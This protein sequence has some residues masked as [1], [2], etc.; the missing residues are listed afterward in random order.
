MDKKP[1]ALV[2]IDGFGYNNSLTGNA[3]AMAKRPSLDFF[4]QNYPY[5]LLQASSNVVGL[6]WGE[7]GNSEV[8]HLT[9]G[10]GRTVRHYLPIINE[11]IANK[12]FFSNKTLLTAIS[13]AKTNNSKLHILGLLTSGSVH[14]Y[15][16]HL[17]ALIE[18]VKKTNIPEVYLHLF[19]DGKDSGTRESLELLKKLDA[20]LEN[21]TQIKIATII[22]R[23][24]AMDRNNDWGK[25]KQAYELTVNGVGS[26]TR[27]FV[28]SLEQ[29]HAKG[30]TDEKIPATVLA[31]LNMPLISDGDALIFFNFREDSIKQLVRPFVEDGFSSFPVKAIPD[32]FVAAFTKYLDSHGLQSFVEPIR[33]KNNLAEWLSVNQKTQLHIAESEKYAHVTLFFNGLENKVYEGETDFFLESPK[34]L[35]NSPEMRSRDIAEKVIEE[36]KRDFYDFFIINFANADMLSHT[37]NIQLVSKGIEKVDEAIGEIYRE[38]Q[39]RGGTLMITSDHG[40]AESLVYGLTGETETKHNLNPVPFYLVADKFQNKTLPKDVSGILSDVAPTILGLMDLP[41][42][43]EMSGKNLLGRIK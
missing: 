25:T 15:F 12:T 29:Y 17:V 14:A 8:G 38:M 28:N 20:E 24:F 26:Q 30:I 23:D 32:L 37:G 9:I 33:V 5:T 39:K 4:E 34:D 35:A 41:V 31:D 7:P 16:K 2:V 6:D 1:L 43:P 40:N 22:G 13:Y 10:A 21:Q 3:I 36:L 18:A 19:T 42:P 27:D 11:A